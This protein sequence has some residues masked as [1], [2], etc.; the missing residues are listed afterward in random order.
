[1][2][3]KDLSTKVDLDIARSFAAVIDDLGVSQGVL[4]SAKGFTDDARRFAKGAGILTYTLADAESVKWRDAALVPVVA[5]FIWLKTCAVEFKN[6][7][8]GNRFGL[9]QDCDMTAVPLVDT[10]AR[11][12]ITV[13]QYLEEHWDAV[14]CDP[15][16]SEPREHG[17]TTGRYA[18]ETPSGLVNVHASIKF[19][20]GCMYHY[21]FIPLQSG[22]A[23]IDADSGRVLLGHEFDTGDIDFHDIRTNWPYVE[24][25][26]DLPLKRPV[27]KLHT[28]ILFRLPDQPID[29]IRVESCRMPKGE[30]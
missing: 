4:V 21:G 6:P 19:T 17:D 3:C 8:T 9:K 20:P 5:N 22:R 11:R 25:E 27:F 10:V 7:K 23:F 26:S 13:K 14:C 15:I 18:L 2:E 1:M 12:R 24:S 30:P 29:G 28:P 16:L